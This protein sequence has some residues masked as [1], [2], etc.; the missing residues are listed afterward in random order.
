MWLRA[1][2]TIGGGRRGHVAIA[3]GTDEFRSF[4]LEGQPVLAGRLS[5]CRYSVELIWLQAVHSHDGEAP[6]TLTVSTLGWGEATIGR[7]LCKCDEGALAVIDAPKRETSLPVCV[8]F[9]RPDRL[10]VQNVYTPPAPPSVPR[11]LFRA[12]ATAEFA[13]ESRM[14]TDSA[15]VGISS[16]TQ[17]PDP[18][19][20]KKKSR[21]VAGKRIGLPFVFPVA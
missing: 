16:A 11:Q 19:Y 4:T 7:V 18:A 6:E 5:S 17:I 2:H 20:Q 8:S 9:L 1:C 3:S 21:P 15:V 12:F 13:T 10:R 14:Q